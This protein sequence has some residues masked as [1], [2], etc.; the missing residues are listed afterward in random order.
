MDHAAFAK[1][2]AL[3][4]RPVYAIERDDKENLVVQWFDPVRAIL[5]RGGGARALHEVS[6]DIL[7]ELFS[8][9]GT[10]V[11]EK[12]MLIFGNKG[13]ISPVVDLTKNFLP[14]ANDMP[15]MDGDS[16]RGL[17]R[18]ACGTVLNLLTGEMRRCQPE[19]RIS[20]STGYAY[21]DWDASLAVKGL[22]ARVCAR[23]N[24]LWGN[25]QDVDDLEDQRL[26]DELLEASPLYR[27]FYSLYED[28]SMAF[29]HLRQ[30]VRAVAGLPGFEELLFLVDSRGSN[31][32]STWLQLLKAI[33]GV[34]GGYFATLDYEK[35]FIGSGMSQKNVPRVPRGETGNST[36]RWP[37]KWEAAGTIQLTPAGS[38][39]TRPASNRS[40]PWSFAPTTSRNFRQMMAGFA[41]ESVTSTCRFSGS[42]TRRTRGNVRLT[43]K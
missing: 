28:H 20:L 24:A 39:R 1:L 5:V 13:F 23:L 34:E 4:L 10:D 43:L 36:R 21:Q 42:R 14:R 3:E 31:G 16:V 22:V 19:D 32:K 11:S 2:V 12:Q 9:M 7:R 27:F 18:F 38:T 6:T 37:R 41:V 33:L 8:N 30:S 25:D 15:P 35:H 40:A 29:W 17:L 26:L